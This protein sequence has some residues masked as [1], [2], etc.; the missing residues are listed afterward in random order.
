MKRLMIYAA[1]LVV[2]FAFSG[3]T[4]NASAEA[5]KAE[6]I[7]FTSNGDSISGWHW[8][9]S[10]GQ[11]ATWTFRTSEFAN[12]SKIFLNFSPLVT[13]GPNGGAGF[14]TAIKVNVD[15]ARSTM[16]TIPVSNPFAPQD[17]AFSN[18]LGYECYGH[19]GAI[20]PAAF[21]GATEIK[22]TIAYPFASGRNVAVRRDSMQIGFSR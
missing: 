6:A 12:A 19:S 17:P 7:S 4:R 20:M 3:P 8:L 5:R 1:M 11:I 13:N 21:A 10:T 15:G 14:A 16:V 9:R 2:L 22:V 18:G